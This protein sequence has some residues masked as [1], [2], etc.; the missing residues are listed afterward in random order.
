LNILEEFSDK[1]IFGKDYDFHSKHFLVR[2]ATRGVLIDETGLIY[3]VYFKNR[4]IY[5]LPG[6]GVDSGETILEGLKREIKEEAGVEFKIEKELGI[7]IETRFYEGMETGLFQISYSYI[8]KLKGEKAI[9]KFVEDEID[10]GASPVWLSLDEAI[11]KYENYSLPDYE[12]H[13]IKHRELAI[14]LEAK[15]YLK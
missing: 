6:G 15:K 13:F 1:E 12:S 4:D 8:L 14:L 9:P 10:E 3:L 2:R 11:S 7:T 5:K